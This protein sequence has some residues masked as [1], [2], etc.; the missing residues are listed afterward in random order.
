[1]G[2]PAGTHDPVILDLSFTQ[3]SSSPVLL[4]ARQGQQ[5][6]SGLILDQRGTPTTDPRDYFEGDLTDTTGHVAVQGSLAA[7]GNGHKGY[8]LLFV[9]GLLAQLLSD[10]SPPWELGADVADPGCF[11]S[12]HMAIDPNCFGPHPTAVADRFIERVATEPRRPNTSSILYPG[13]RSQQLRRAREAAGT[14]EV[15]RPQVAAML[16]LAEEL[17]VDVPPGLTPPGAF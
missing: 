11:G 13:A 12:V 17:G 1:V 9:I 2:I 4:A 16:A 8:A 10:T 3:T 14:V 15:P 6:P 5:V 7:L